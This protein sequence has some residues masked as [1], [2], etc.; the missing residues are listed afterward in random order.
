MDTRFAV[1]G[2]LYAENRK[3]CLLD[4]L[5]KCK[6]RPALLVGVQSMRVLENYVS[7]YVD[8]CLQ[9]VPD[10]T[11]VRWYDSFM[12]YLATALQ[13]KEEFFTVSSELETRGFSDDEAAVYYLELL[14]AFA[15]EYG[16]CVQTPKPKSG[17]VRAFRLDRNKAMELFKKQICENS[18]AY[19]GVNNSACW[20]FLHMDDGGVICAISDDPQLIDKYMDELECLPSIQMGEKIRHTILAPK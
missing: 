18:E 6:K 2:K 9:F 19:F 17:E 11:T 10:S 13:I 1:K 14:E 15:H 16:V 12:Q 5:L 3:R 8:A 20:N 4:T 7:G